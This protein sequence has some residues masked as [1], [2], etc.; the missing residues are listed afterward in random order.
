MLPQYSALPLTVLAAKLV[1]AFL[2]RG[3][4][5]QR[6]VIEGLVATA[7]AIVV[8]VPDI[9]VVTARS[10][11]AR[12]EVIFQIKQITGI[13]LSDAVAGHEAGGA[14][15]AA[16]LQALVVLVNVGDGGAVGHAGKHARGIVSCAGH[17]INRMGRVEG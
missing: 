14:G 13:A 5:I 11:I 6:V 8:D 17:I 1:P 9:A 7:I 16:D 10:A 3:E 15:D 4:A 12:V 2:R